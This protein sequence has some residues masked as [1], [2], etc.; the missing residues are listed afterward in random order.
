ML[1]EKRGF[2][3]GS[4]R[5]RLPSANLDNRYHHH[6]SADKLW[7]AL[8]RVYLVV[9]GLVLLHQVADASVRGVQ[10][11]ELALL[12]STISFAMVKAVN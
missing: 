2:V 11:M 8:E 3:L 5:G 6:R 4:A 12:W 7:I 9:I 10:C 1:G